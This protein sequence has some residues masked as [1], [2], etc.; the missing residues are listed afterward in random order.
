[1]FL[2]LGGVLAIQQGTR[3]NPSLPSQQGLGNKAWKEST[4]IRGRQ[5]MKG[6]GMGRGQILVGREEVSVDGLHRS[7]RWCS[8]ES[9]KG[10][11]EPS[12]G[13]GGMRW[14]KL[15]KEK[16]INMSKTP[17]DS[18]AGS[19]TSHPPP[20]PSPSLEKPESVSRRREGPGVPGQPCSWVPP[21]PLSTWGRGKSCEEF[22]PT[23]RQK[24]QKKLLRVG[25]I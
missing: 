16:V 8:A 25:R 9:V 7:C 20:T 3:W 18:E 23:C 14:L 4:G 22:S 10:R 1:M 15:W 17:S 2:E 13:L 21:C 6:T 11:A 24:C 5:Q 12:K 19:T